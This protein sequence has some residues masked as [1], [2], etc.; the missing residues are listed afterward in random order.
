MIIFIR[1]RVHTVGPGFVDVDVQ[2]VGYR[3]YIPE[4]FAHRLEPNAN[5]L[6]YTYHHI[7]EDMQ[8]LFGFETQADRDW[9][10]LLLGVSGIGPKGAMQIISAT[11]YTSFVQAVVQEDV[12]ALASLPGIGKKTA[13]RLIV[14]LRDKLRTASH[15]G[16]D[17]PKRGQPGVAS[18]VQE[19]VEALTALGY[20]EREARIACEQV[21]REP[22]DRP[23]ETLIRLCL[24]QLARV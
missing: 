10:E 13:Q 3:V 8:L 4:P 22:E 2:G 9:F 23:L 5:I 17:P 20:H 14:E 19:V 18:A 16:Q 1:G 7:R 24:Q 21:L 12:E 11:S 15:I 6:L